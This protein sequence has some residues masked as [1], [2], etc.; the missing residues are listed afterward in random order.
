MKIQSLTWKSDNF[1]QAAPAI[2][3]R[4]AGGTYGVWIA[5]FREGRATGAAR[6]LGAGCRLT[7]AE[8]V[9]GAKYSNLAMGGPSATGDF[10]MGGATG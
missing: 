6:P 4:L 10:Q 7:E 2:A 9:A 8:A 3:V 5:L 1:G